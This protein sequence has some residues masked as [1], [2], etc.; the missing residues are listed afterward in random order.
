MVAQRRRHNGAVT[1]TGGGGK[2]QL[3]GRGA[4]FKGRTR[5]WLRVAETVGGSGRRSRGRTRRRPRSEH[6]RHGGAIVQ[7]VWLMGGQGSQ[8]R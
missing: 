1:A 8:I 2:G 6:G 3:T 4:P 7:T 5:R